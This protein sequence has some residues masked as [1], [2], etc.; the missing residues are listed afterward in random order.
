MWYRITS[1]EVNIEGI[2]RMVNDMVLVCFTIRMVGCTRE[3][4]I[5]IKCMEEANYIINQVNLHM[6]ENGV[7]INFQEMVVSIM[8]NLNHLHNHLTIEILIKLNKDGLNIKV[9]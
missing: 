5:R 6:K 4:G 3:N 2:S 8:S 9:Y 7:M 1:R